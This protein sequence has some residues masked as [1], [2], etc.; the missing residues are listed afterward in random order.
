MKNVPNVSLFFFYNSLKKSVEHKET[1]RKKT[2][3]KTFY[4]T[5]K[6]NFMTIKFSGTELWG[7][8]EC[9]YGRS[10]LWTMIT[11][12]FGAFCFNHFVYQKKKC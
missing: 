5:V 10:W 3:N 8:Y 7:T 6:V 4:K 12:N 1:G 9:T 11:M 2:L